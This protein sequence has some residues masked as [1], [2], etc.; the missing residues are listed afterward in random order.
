MLNIFFKILVLNICGYTSQKKMFVGEISYQ[1]PSI[2]TRL[3]TFNWYSS[4]GGIFSSYQYT[5]CKLSC[6]GFFSSK[7][8]K[9]SLYVTSVDF[10]VPSSDLSVYTFDIYIL[11]LYSPY[12][13][14]VA[15]CPHILNSC[16]WHYCWLCIPMAN[17][18]FFFKLLVQWTYYHISYID[19]CRHNKW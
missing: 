2:I 3:N 5:C 15:N 6:G 16:C 17:W 11:H 19:Y 1:K 9:M 4:R 13:P 8:C 14:P 18:F 7:D 10:D 12:N